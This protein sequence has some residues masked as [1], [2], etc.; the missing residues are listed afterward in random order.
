MRLSE[1]PLRGQK[2]KEF[3]LSAATSFT[4]YDPNKD[5][6]V[7]NNLLLAKAIENSGKSTDFEI[8]SM[9]QHN[10]HQSLLLYLKQ[11]IL[12]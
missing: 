5:Q 2:N 10:T 7:R 11:I 9:M 1:Q 3:F 12:I 6:G 8:T 4:P